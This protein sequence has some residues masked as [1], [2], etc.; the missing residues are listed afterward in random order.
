MIQPNMQST[1]FTTNKIDALL[2]AKTTESLASQWYNQQYLS[3][4]ISRTPELQNYEV[5]ELVFISKLFNSALSLD[6]INHLLT[7]LSKPYAYEYQHIYFDVFSNKWSYLSE[8]ID[9]D[10][11]EEIEIDEEEIANSYIENLSAESDKN[12]IE[13]L[14]HY[15]QG[16]LQ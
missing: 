5:L 8:E 15:L 13:R 6:T 2:L 3:F 1:L 10:E 16:L 4:D 7:L 12:E 9:E 14:I 11:N